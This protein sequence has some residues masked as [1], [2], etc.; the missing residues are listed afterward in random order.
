MDLIHHWIQVQSYKHN[1]ALH[2]CWDRN[3]V[4]TDN[5]D[6][7]VVAS[8]R[9]KVTEGDGRRWYTHE[10]AVTVFS[11][12]DWYNVICMLKEDGVNFYCNIASPT[13]IDKGMAKYIDYD[14][15]LKLYPDGSI[16]I[17]DQ[18]E[19]EKHKAQLN[20]GSDLDTVIQKTVEIVT[21]KMHSKAFPF[22]EDIVTE[23][24]D[25]FEKIVE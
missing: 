21:S 23:Y 20:Y 11:K 9:T 6:F 10:P 18:N 15:D 4:I 25:A 12:K 2:R 1:G 22:R 17:L 7:I 5:D 14:L 13:L 16:R 24:F 3:F 8:R 19:Y